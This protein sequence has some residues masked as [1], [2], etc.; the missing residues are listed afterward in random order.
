VLGDTGAGMN[1][2]STMFSFLSPAKTS[3]TETGSSDRIY[4]PSTESNPRKLSAAPS[5]SSEP[6]HPR[7]PTTHFPP[8]ETQT[9][10]IPPPTIPF[11]NFLSQIPLSLALQTSSISTQLPVFKVR[12]RSSKIHRHL[13]G[14][15]AESPIT[16]KLSGRST[17][18]LVQAAILR[19]HSPIGDE[20]DYDAVPDSA[21]FLNSSSIVFVTDAMPRF[22]W[23][24]EVRTWVTS[25]PP[26]TKRTGHSDGAWEVHDGVQA[27][28][29]VFE[30]AKSMTEWLSHL[31]TTIEGIMKG[32]QEEGMGLSWVPLSNEPL[33]NTLL[34]TTKPG[35][36]TLSSSTTTVT[37]CV[38][39]TPSIHPRRSFP[40][41]IEEIS[42]H[43]NSSSDIRLNESSSS[44]TLSTKMDELH[45]TIPDELQIPEQRRP[46]Q[47][48]ISQS[49]F[50]IN[51]HDY[52][53]CSQPD[54]S[55]RGKSSAQKS[56]V[57]RYVPP[58]SPNTTH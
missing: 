41:S 42:T 22:Q 8:V 17:F 56:I 51:L 44:S 28:R 45:L 40:S 36:T 16:F 25:T 9:Q 34:I 43:G 39:S 58:V 37:D 30:T 23:V 53:T 13:F 12:N 1:P 50:S 21:H 15:S 24:L 49:A 31:R 19:Y 20:L 33:R 48:N 10:F 14:S 11:Q 7:P 55:K 18:A 29:M 32:R 3:R 2:R 26:V 6:Q 46:S 5:S 52:K 27:W 54:I 4:V 47:C 35:S 57:I 38:A